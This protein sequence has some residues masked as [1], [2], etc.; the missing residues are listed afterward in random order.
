VL[1]LLAGLGK[2]AKSGVTAAEAATISSSDCSRFSLID[3]D[4]CSEMPLTLLRPE[5]PRHAALCSHRNGYHPRPVNG[6][7]IV[8]WLSRVPSLNPS[9]RGVTMKARDETG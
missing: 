7:P 8:N 5:C 4:A 3:A 2:D 1:A 6:Y 9:G